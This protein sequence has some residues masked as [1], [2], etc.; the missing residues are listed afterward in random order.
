[1]SIDWITVLAQ[2]GNFLLL[3]WLLKRFLY[4]PILDG[5]DAREAEIARRMAEAESAREQAQQAEQRYQSA[6]AQTLAE[7]EQRVAQALQMTEGERE[8]MMAE[9][10]A[11][12]EQQRGDWQRHLEQE[13]REFSQR[14]QR[15]GGDLMLELT[16]KALREL[17]DAP[18]EAAIVR[19]IGRQL[20]PL[21]DELTAA[22][23]EA[24]RGTLSSHDP[25]SADL[26]QALRAELAPLLPQ[27]ELD[28]VVDAQQAPGLV[29]QVGGA[30]LAWTTD[31]YM[32]ELDASLLP[33]RAAGESSLAAGA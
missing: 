9:A 33:E 24:T 21:A 20:P 17:A 15:A 23:G 4:R 32:D 27:V 18:V 30:R 19:H 2:L 13:G 16:R 3:V 31:S 11:Q 28:F 5:I 10:R 14:L 6:Y 25:L 26:Q 22:A 1:M 29:L 12:I 7:Q 8:Q